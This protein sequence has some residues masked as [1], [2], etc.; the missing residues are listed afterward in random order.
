MEETLVQKFGNSTN[1]CKFIVELD[2]SKEMKKLPEVDESQLENNP[3]C[4]E[5]SIP[6]TEIV[7]G[8]EW[9]ENEQGVLINK[10]LYAEKTARVELYIHTDSGNNVAGL[11]DKA[12]RLY[13]HVLYTLK[14]KKDWV[15]INSEYYM[16]RNNVKSFTTYSNA[17]KEL[18]R[19]QFLCK[20]HM[21][22]VYWLNPHRFFPGSRLIK[23]PDKKRIIQKWDQKKA[24]KNEDNEPKIPFSFNREEFEN[25]QK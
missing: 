2:K 5:L 1:G 24:T 8:V 11:S 14:P 3:F 12:Q 21:K 17:I 25:D 23:Y 20:T 10:V 6:V 18:V 22:D 13:L 4:Q 16:K 15:Q 7:K 9:I 19:Y